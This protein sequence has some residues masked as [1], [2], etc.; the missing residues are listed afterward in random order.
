MKK[1]VIGSVEHIQIAKHGETM[2][3]AKIDTGADYS[4]VWV[5]DIQHTD[6]VLSFVFFGPGSAYYTG[7]V[8]KTRRFKITNIK[9]S[10]GDSEVRYKIQLKI[11][12]GSHQRIN[13]FSLADRSRTTYPI[14]LGKSFLK[15]SFIV[16]VDQRH[17]YGDGDE[18]K[19]VLVVS[20]GS[21]TQPFLEKVEKTIDGDV[22]LKSTR[23]DDL[24]F[25]IDGSKSDIIDTSAGNS[26]VV[27]HDLIYVKS[28]WK[29]P[30][31]ASALAEYLN[32]RNVDFID[33]EIGEYT[34]RGKLSEMMRL[35]THAIPVPRAFA[36]YPAVLLSQQDMIIES[37]GFPFVLKS[38][39]AD[40]GKDNYLVDS[41]EVYQKILTD[42]EST[43][44]FIAQ[45]YVKNDG[46]YRLN[47]FGGEVKLA[48][49]RS[50]H[51]HADPLKRH[52]NKPSGGVNAQLTDI[53]T[54]PS[55][56]VE[57]SIKAAYYMKRQIAGVDILQDTQTGQWYIL[58][59]NNSPQIRTGSHAEEKL[60]AF[61]D[62]IQRRLEK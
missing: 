50:A 61:S 38:A 58:E 4:A 60:K 24:L 29:H 1:A 19:S 37:L 39:A 44:I 15:D 54:L 36:G 34:S 46:F 16:D 51:T 23:F 55:S 45:V 12:M 25:C 35:S 47:V 49:F 22:R 5:T 48:V 33:Q 11:K 6:G 32:F 20:A 40:K 56:M 53:D 42:S 9:N 52:L 10:F 62:Y 7:E 59:V 41:I 2:V 8:H 21:K 18:A 30:E 43:S 57:L 13:W 26:S 28:H 3:L 31:P 27:T 14:L 17:I